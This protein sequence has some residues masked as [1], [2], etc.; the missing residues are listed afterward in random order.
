MRTLRV[1]GSIALLIVLGACASNDLVARPNSPTS[2]IVAIY[3][4][5]VSANAGQTLTLSVIVTDSSGTAFVPDSVH[6]ISDDTTKATVSAAGV[7]RTVQSTPEV[8]IH[9]T[10]FVGLVQGTAQCPVTISQ[11]GSF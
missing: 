11:F 9:A 10:A 7:L 4:P 2:I 8:T 1:G 5:L 3:P 6:W